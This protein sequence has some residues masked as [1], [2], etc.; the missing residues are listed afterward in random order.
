MLH[1]YELEKGIQELTRKVCNQI[2]TWALEQ[3]DT[4]LMNERDRST[5]EVVGFRRRTAIS[6]FEEFHFKRRLYRK[7]SWAPTES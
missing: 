5:W 7:F 4:R 6:T 1:F 3:I 2:F